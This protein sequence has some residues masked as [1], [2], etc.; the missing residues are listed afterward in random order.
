VFCNPSVT[1]PATLII[2]NISILLEKVAEKPK[3]IK[4]LLRILRHFSIPAGTTTPITGKAGIYSKKNHADAFS[5]PFR[6]FYKTIG[7]T[8]QRHRNGLLKTSA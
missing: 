8:F 4:F 6:W 7:M 3:K 2:V 5:K 1:H